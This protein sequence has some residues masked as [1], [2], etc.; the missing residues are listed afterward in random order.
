MGYSCKSCLIQHKRSTIGGRNKQAIAVGL[1]T[2]KQQFTELVGA[3][4]YQNIACSLSYIHEDLLL[5]E[6]N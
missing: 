1:W 2:T 3:T 4:Q 5:G 6:V